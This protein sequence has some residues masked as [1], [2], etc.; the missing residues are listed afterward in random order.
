MVLYRAEYQGGSANKVVA[1][2][3]EITNVE[4]FDQKVEQV[5]NS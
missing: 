3:F 5:N 4:V 1:F 2:T